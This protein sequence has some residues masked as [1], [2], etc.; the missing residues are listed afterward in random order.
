[1]EHTDV[2]RV[3][4]GD[5]EL[6]HPGLSAELTPEAFA[7]TCH[8]TGAHG[9]LDRCRRCG[10]VQQ[11]SLPGG[12][13]LVELYRRMRDDAY[14]REE[15]GRRRTA[16][17]VL[18]LVARH[19]PRGRLLDVGCGHGLLTDEARRR[20]YAAEGLEISEGAIAHARGVLGLPIRETTLE[21]PALD[22]ERFD[23]IVLADVLEHFDDPC[24][25]LDRCRALLAPDGALVVITP[26]PSSRTARIAGARWWG[27]LPAHVCLIPHRTVIALLRERGLD[28]CED[29]P[30][31][32]SFTP[33]TWVGGL[34]ERAGKPGHLAISAVGRL[35]RTML[36]SLSLGD[37]RVLVARP[38]AAG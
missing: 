24:T 20:G 9:D 19:V 2:C 25:A 34:L 11:R 6:L 21:D 33:A 18:D 26:D 30:F 27:F 8:T 38:R 12:D 36:W 35:P 13:E 3:C 31:V 7:P 32:R 4:S 29:V 23:V 16:R 37:E 17:A 28:A 1:M 15:E 10:T 22:D 14:L 5:L